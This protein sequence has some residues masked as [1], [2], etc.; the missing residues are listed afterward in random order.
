MQN[1]FPCLCSTLFLRNF[2]A[3]L[4]EIAREKGVEAAAIEIWFADEARIG[5]KNK[6]TRRWAK[7]GTRPM[8]HHQ[9][10]A[11]S[12]RPTRATSHSSST[13]DDHNQLTGLVAQK[14]LAFRSK[15][16]MSVESA[17]EWSC[18]DTLRPGDRSI[19]GLCQ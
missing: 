7:R 13:A 2:P 16:S 17:A 14:G 15:E 5:Q 10:T 8:L 18:A 9:R 3:R 19:R 6:I 1:S 12:P 4:D 11:S